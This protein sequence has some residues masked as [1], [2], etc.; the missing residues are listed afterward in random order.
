MRGSRSAV[1]CRRPARLSV[2]SQLLAPIAL[3]LASLPINWKRVIPSELLT[4][5]KDER[6]SGSRHFQGKADDDFDVFIARCN[7]PITH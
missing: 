5:Q 7:Q 3:L 2:A 6:R 1:S 4:I